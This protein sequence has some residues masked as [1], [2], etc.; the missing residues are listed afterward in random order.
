MFKL[1]KMVSTFCLIAAISILGYEIVRNNRALQSGLENKVPEI[2][3]KISGVKKEAEEKLAAARE[4]MDEAS[5]TREKEDLKQNKAF[6]QPPEFH[7]VPSVQEKRSEAAPKSDVR[8][9][10]IDRE[11]RELTEKILDKSVES[12][13]LPDKPAHSSEK[14]LKDTP[15][16]SSGPLLP[17]EESL[18]LERVSKISELYSNAN[19]IL[20]WE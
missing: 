4:I 14:V 8:L 5:N 18:D 13:E 1:I 11:D 3:H 17:Q 16:T 6:N 7:S 20:N 12:R 19:E 2:R 9:N 15:L 10:P